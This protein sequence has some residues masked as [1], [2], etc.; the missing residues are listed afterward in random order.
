MTSRSLEP[1][2]RPGLRKSWCIAIGVALAMV[3]CVTHRVAPEL[4][5]TWRAESAVD[6]YYNV[7]VIYLE[8][9]GKFF[10]VSSSTRT[11]PP[12]TG[13]D[14][15]VL[16]GASGTWS[17]RGS[18]LR[19]QTRA[20]GDTFGGGSLGTVSNLTTNT[21]TTATHG[22]TLVWQRLPDKTGETVARFAR[23]MDAWK[24]SEKGAQYW[25]KAP[26]MADIAVLLRPIDGNIP[27]SKH[28]PSAEGLTRLRAG[29]TEAEAN[30]LMPH[31]HGWKSF[32]WGVASFYPTG[33][34][35][36]LESTAPEDLTPLVFDKQKN[37]LG[38]GQEFLEEK[39]R[40]EEAKKAATAAREKL[41]PIERNIASLP[42]VKTNMTEIEVRTLAPGF[43]RWREYPWG[44]VL[45]YPVEPRASAL[46]DDRSSPKMFLR[47]NAYVP[48][49][50]GTN[51]TV[52]GV[53]WDFLLAQSKLKSASAGVD[54]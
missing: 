11:N 21:F 9:S 4:S 52:I 31:P 50:F 38:W 37:L 43:S 42:L 29:M 17:Q 32:T 2:V 47:N 3:V 23:K 35:H 54:K 44:K 20:H 19:T 5:G 45:W 41:P 18:E 48:V 39:I 51:Q 30:H 12:V 22:A 10:T 24:Y 6:G 8:R 33:M 46:L 7:N 25:G 13:Y 34:S 14:P 27:L 26:E 49:V 16:N 36:G 1:N 28:A 40:E 53:G 15:H